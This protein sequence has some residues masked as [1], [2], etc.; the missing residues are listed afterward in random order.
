[1]R[2]GSGSSDTQHKPCSI[3]MRW[4][5]ILPNVRRFIGRGCHARSPDTIRTNKTKAARP[6]SSVTG[7]SHATTSLRSCARMHP[8]EQDSR[9]S[10]EVCEDGVLAPVG[11]WQEEAHAR[12]QETPPS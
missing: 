6:C 2:V 12:Q 9:Y 3:S 5:V 8:S 11:G 10:I 1:M 4:L 7:T